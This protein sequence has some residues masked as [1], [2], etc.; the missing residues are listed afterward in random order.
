MTNAAAGSS[1]TAARSVIR[2]EYS[3]EQP[4]SPT[5]PSTL[6]AYLHSC[7]QPLPSCWS[8]TDK[9]AGM[10]ISERQLRATYQGIFSIFHW[11]RSREI[12]Y[13]RF[14][15]ESECPYSSSIWGVLLGNQD[16]K[17]GPRRLHCHRV[18]RKVCQPKS[19]PWY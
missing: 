15:G 17:Q 13:R 16:C 10:G 9:F 14:N 2:S 6:P 18:Y 12:G 4:Q 7:S 5:L 1:R 3:I 11:K 19:T 8:S